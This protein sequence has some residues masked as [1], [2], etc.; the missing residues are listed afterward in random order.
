MKSYKESSFQDRRGRAAEAKAK[1]LEQLC[2]R[3]PVSAEVRA[4]R[5]AASLKR[6]AVKAGK[7]AAKAA[8]KRAVTDAAVAEALARATVPLQPSEADRKAMR[9]ARYAARKRR[10]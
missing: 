8:K 2:S 9:D 6:D 5:M 10:K 3:P 7:V 4:E 1:A